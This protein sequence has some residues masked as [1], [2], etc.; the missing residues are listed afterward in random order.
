[1]V[2]LILGCALII[3]SILSWLTKPTE[4]FCRLKIWLAAFGWVFI[5]ASLISKEV[6]F[7]SVFSRKSLLRRRTAH[8]LYRLPIF[9]ALVL[10]LLETIIVQMWVSKD[11][12]TVS[13]VPNDPDNLNLEWA[14]QC[15]YFSVYTWMVHVFTVFNAVLPCILIALSALNRNLPQE[16]NSTTSIIF[17]SMTELFMGLLFFNIK[18]FGYTYILNVITQ[19]IFLL[20][21]TCFTGVFFIGPFF[22][23]EQS[24]SEMQTQRQP[25]LWN[26][27]KRIKDVAE[28][29]KVLQKKVDKPKNTGLLKRQLKI[30]NNRLCLVDA[31]ELVRPFYCLLFMT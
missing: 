12:V 7:R 23:L 30:T 25:R 1:M 18:S 22:L 27:F 6:L 21:Y 28:N 20:I 15:N 9:V 31:V 26:P 24:T 4:L 13:I 10:L 2:A 16:Y 19:I 17:F 14:P 29:N 5:H 8:V 3:S 11:T